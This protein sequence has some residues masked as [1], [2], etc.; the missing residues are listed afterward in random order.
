MVKALIVYDSMYGNTEKIARAIGEAITGDARV[1]RVGEVSPPDMKSIN[2]FIVG[3]PTQGFRA[4]K[5]VQTFIE[6]IPKD[7]LKGMKVAAF[8]TRMPADEVGKGLRFIMKVGGYA[9]PRIAEALK[10]RGGN[11]VAPPEGFLVKGKEGPVKEGE[12]ERA[13]SWAKVIAK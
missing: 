6:G 4:T 5:P 10:K 11:L 8:D 2:F 1:L 9:A 12:I 3:S 7:V 13:A